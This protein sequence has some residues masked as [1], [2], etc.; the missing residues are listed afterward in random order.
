MNL[1]KSVL[2]AVAG[3]IVALATSGCGDAP[4]SQAASPGPVRNPMEI[5]ASPELMKQLEI[6]APQWKNVS[7]LLRVAGRVEADETRMARIN[8]PVNGRIVDLNVIEGQHVEKGQVLAT[9]YST[10]L[11]SAQSALVKA[12]TQHQLA[13]RAVARARQLLEA[14]VIGSA[15]LQ[16]REGELEQAVADLASLR[17]QLLVL[18][19][20]KAAVDHLESTRAIDSI[21]EIVSTISGRVLERR[22]TPGQVLQ[23]AEVLCIVADLSSVW[24]VADVPEQSAGSIRI[25]KSVHAEIPALPGEK[26]TGTLSFV[27]SMVNPETRTVRTRMNL[28]NPDR[29]YKPAMLATMTLVDGA[30]RRLVVPLSAVVRNGNQDGIFIRKS[31]NEFVLR[32]VEL[33]EEFGDERVVLSGLDPEASIVVQGAFHLNNERMRVALRGTHSD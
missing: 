11:S 12:K 9:I 4:A 19:M 31:G 22:V 10:E 32:P 17:E 3:G 8:A 23:A 5:E 13:E 33:G 6:A 14:G 21:T 30:E 25:G 15:E 29:R 16:R 18:G 7:G 24:L 28:A 26:I 1:S 2:I 20:R 27:S